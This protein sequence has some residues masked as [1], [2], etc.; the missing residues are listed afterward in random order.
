M[1][2]TLSLRVYTGADAGTESAA[3][4]GVDM[5]SAD[6]A[7]NSLANRQANPVGVGT[8]SYEKWLKLKV[9]A[10]PDNGVT[11]FLA[12]GDGAVGTSTDLMVAGEVV[13]GATPVATESAVA[14]TTFT[15]YTAGNK[16][17][18]DTASYTA[19]DATTKYLVLQLQAEATANPGN[20]PQETVN[21]SFDET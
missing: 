18:W 19:T 1:V 16:L 8:N 12:W 14:V 5:I 3:V 13:T 20:W 2:A 4:T 9:D 11:N 21:Y 15:Q 17:A 6:N 10:A 7:T